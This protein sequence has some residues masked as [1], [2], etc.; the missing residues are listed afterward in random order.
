MRVVPDNKNTAS[1]WSSSKYATAFVPNTLPVRPIISETHMAIALRKREKSFILVANV[2]V[3]KTQYL[4]LVGYNSTVAALTTVAANPPHSKMMNM[5]VAI[6]GMSTK[7]TAIPATPHII[8]TK[9][10]K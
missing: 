5:Y 6:K 8:R 4:K 1:Q 3:Q 9:T 2:Y 7:T 10:E